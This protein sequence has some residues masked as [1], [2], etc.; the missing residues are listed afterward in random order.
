MEHVGEKGEPVR[1][2]VID[3]E[4]VIRDLLHDMLSSRDYLVTTAEDAKSGLTAAR[5]TQYQVIFTD[6][7]M[8][9]MNGLDVCRQLRQECPDSRV[10]MM[11]GYGLEEMIQEALRLGAFASVK[12][13]FDIQ[14]I[15]D[16]VDRAIGSARQEEAGQDE[17]PRRP[18]D[19][20]NARH[21]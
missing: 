3:D 11:T 2:L 10:I 15:Y 17:A 8:P 9:G 18:E 16:L 14:D 1:I 4:Q 21:D 19:E 12:K 6:I 13:P 20:D 7:R 5:S